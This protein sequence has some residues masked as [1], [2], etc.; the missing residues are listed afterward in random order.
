MPFS[1]SI[2]RTASTI[3]LLLPPLPFVDQVG[4]HDR[5]VRDVDRLPGLGCE[6]EGPLARRLH[7]S[8]AAPRLGPQAHAPAERPLEVRTRAQRTL[9]PRRGDL[10][11]VAV[12]I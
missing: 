12:E 6:R 2:S 8:Q 5:V 3:S 7:L 1:R 9:D 11:R 10:H 4:P